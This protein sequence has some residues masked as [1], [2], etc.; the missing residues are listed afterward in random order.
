MFFE[1]FAVKISNKNRRGKYD[2]FIKVMN[3]GINSTI[4]DV[5]FTGEEQYGSPNALEKFYPCQQNITALGI[6]D[7][8]EFSKRYPE[9]KVV[10]YD[11]NTFPFGS[12]EF[13]FIWSNAVLEHVGGYEKQKYFL[14]EVLRTGKRIYIT[15][16]NRFFPIEVHTRLP[17][18][19]FLPKKIFDKLLKILNKGWAAGDYMNLLSVWD[20]KKMLKELGVVDY[21]I[22]RNRFFLFTMDFII[23]V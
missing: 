3:P 20:I 11:G 10:L 14:S 8:K 23:I 4:L 1:K 19:Q 21:K 12:K 5:G 13:D 6:A 2:Y 16:P 22:K 15:T 7:S 18:L 17:L 9:V